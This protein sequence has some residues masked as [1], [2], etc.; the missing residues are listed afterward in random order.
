MKSRDY[1][2]QVRQLLG[3]AEEAMNPFN[4]TT[5]DCRVHIQQAAAR[6]DHNDSRR[7]TLVRMEVASSRPDLLPTLSIAMTSE[8]YLLVKSTFWRRSG[9]YWHSC[10]DFCFIEPWI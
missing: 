6:F 4:I 9:R 2:P 10:S 1:H 3:Y 5:S 7:S 8:L